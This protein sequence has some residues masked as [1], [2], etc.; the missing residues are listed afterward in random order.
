MKWPIQWAPTFGNLAKGI[1]IIWPIH[2]TLGT[3]IT[4]H[5]YT[6]ICII[7]SC[8]SCNTVL[9]ASIN[10]YS[11]NRIEW[12]WETYLLRGKI[13]ELLVDWKGT[14]VQFHYS[15]GDFACFNT[16]GGL[17]ELQLSL[18]FADHISNISQTIQATRNNS[19]YICVSEKLTPRLD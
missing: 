6:A 7:A 11:S 12:I 5:S 2:T 14:L 9:S 3:M 4:H 1:S 17:L 10:L 13:M 8:S 19:E 16:H 15:Y 18:V